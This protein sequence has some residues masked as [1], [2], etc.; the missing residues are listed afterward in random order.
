MNETLEK[1]AKVPPGLRPCDGIMSGL[2]GKSP[3]YYYQLEETGVPGDQH[4]W[5]LVKYRTAFPDGYF[6]TKMTDKRETVW[7]VRMDDD[8]AEWLA[9]AVIAEVAVWVHQLILQVDE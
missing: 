7:H 1:L 6:S 8:R 3:A 5:Y 4:D 9:D 2:M